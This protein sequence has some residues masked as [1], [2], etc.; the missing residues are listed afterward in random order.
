MIQDQYSS[1]G[2]VV[3]VERSVAIRRLKMG[4]GTPRSLQQDSDEMSTDEEV[5]PANARHQ[6]TLVLI[7][8]V[9]P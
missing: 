6:P 5:K 8:P 1:E 7:N 9:L 2:E 4:A 3:H